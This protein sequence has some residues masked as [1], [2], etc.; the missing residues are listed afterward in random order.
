MD[1][2]VIADWIMTAAADPLTVCVVI[3]LATLLAE[4][5]TTIVVGI[6]VSQALLT[7]APALSA[8]LAGTISG[9]VMLHLAGRYAGDSGWGRAV[10]RGAKVGVAVSRLRRPTL[11]MVGLAR[12]VPGMRLPVYFGSGFLRMD[13]RRCLALIVLTGSVWTPALFWTSATGG[14]VATRVAGGGPWPLLLSA[15]FCFVGLWIVRVRARRQT[16]IIG[17][18]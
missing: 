11:W 15:M 12:F 4:D 14:D 3:F 2:S 17:A 6:L 7:P 18:F 9:D 16:P 8:L 10:L 1:S 13:W 5:A